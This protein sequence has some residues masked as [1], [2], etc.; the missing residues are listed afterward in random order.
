MKNLE[1]ES[2]VSQRIYNDYLRRVER[3]AKI[4]SN[5][6]KSDILMEINSHIYEGMQSS[7]SENESD[8]LLTIIE[9]LGAPEEYLRPILA[10]KKINEATRTFKPIAIYQ[11][12]KL[13]LKNGI[14]YSVFAILYLSL[15]VFVFLILSKIVF[16]SRT[17]LFFSDGEFHAF[18][19]LSDTSG[20]NEIL[21]FWFIPLVIIVAAI[22]Y[23]MITLLFRLVRKK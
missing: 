20:L 1:F 19:L 4:L 2:T 6:D 16:P 9:N 5:D 17:G 22:F 8:R 13:N 21:G 7:T 18:G 23:L 14:I 3:N 15:A 10:E 11:A 12:L